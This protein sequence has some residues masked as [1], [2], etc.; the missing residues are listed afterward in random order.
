MIYIKY[1]LN[2]TYHDISRHIYDVHVTSPLH[3]QLRYKASAP[4]DRRRAPCPMTLGSLAKIHWILIEKTAVCNF[5]VCFFFQN[6]AVLFLN[7][8]RKMAL[9]VKGICFHWIKHER[10]QGFP[11]I[12]TVVVCIWPPLDIRSLFSPPLLE[13]ELIVT[14]C[15]QDCEQSTE[16]RKVF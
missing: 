11:E 3:F 2:E 9:M 10:I 1:V 13:E 4:G 16:K 15:Y 6:S 5:F 14:W 7:E 12:G 8:V